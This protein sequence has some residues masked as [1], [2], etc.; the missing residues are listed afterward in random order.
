MVSNILFIFLA[1]LI[2]GVIIVCH[3]LGHFIVG[4]FSGI[5]V[6]EFSVGF[7]PKLLGWKRKG[8]DYSIRAIPLGGFCKF[9]GEDENNDAP[10]AFNNA[11]V[12]KRFLTVLA[13]PVMNGVL[14]LV[15]TILLLALNGTVWY[16]P[17]I[18]SVIEG[19][20]AEAAGLLPGDLIT[21]VDGERLTADEAGMVRMQ[22]MVQA[23][24]PGQTL[25]LTVKR[26]EEEI[27]I[28]LQ[29]R[30][31]EADERMQ[32]GIYFGY[33]HR[34]YR[35]TEL[36]PESFRY[37]RELLTMMLDSLGKLFFHGQG[38]QD[39]MGAV[40]VI[41]TMGSS[42]QQGF[43]QTAQAGFAVIFYM[44]MLI[45]LNLGIMNLLPLPALDGGRLVFLLVEGIRRKPVPP[46]KEGLV[47]G[48]GLL[49]LLG[50]SVV[51]M[52]QDIIR[53]VSGGW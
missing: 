18:D 22:E 37:M 23:A 51:I 24:Q 5:G 26:G 36:I 53:I 2:L 44:I 29:P 33:Q 50:L 16:Q 13:G 45:S 49:L 21:S 8:I 30:Y 14:A 39:T 7:G 42:V 28:A 3:E 10:D 25:E 34:A 20:P 19:M 40:G 48:I 4:R 43:Q 32:I 9:K 15:A 35:I 47:H 38:L 46:E 27:S 17:M 31:S 12:W 41:S 52:Y 6:L 11:K 1:I